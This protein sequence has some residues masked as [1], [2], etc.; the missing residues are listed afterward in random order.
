MEPLISRYPDRLMYQRDAGFSYSNLCDVLRETGRAVQASDA[1]RRAVSIFEALVSR[2]PDVSHN[3]QGRGWAYEQVG[4]VLR[5]TG[6]AAEASQVQ[7]KA[8]A[9]FEAMTARSPIPRISS[10]AWQW[11][12]S[13]S[14][15]P[16]PRPAGRRG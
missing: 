15:S 12:I 3:Q 11:V 2:Q 1:S 5:E 4:E 7:S 8:V 14:A 6:H 16:S 9:I 10:T 13:G